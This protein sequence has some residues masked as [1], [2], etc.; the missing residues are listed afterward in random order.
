MAFVEIAK[1]DE[2]R[3]LVYGWANIVKHADGT[4][5]EDSQGDLIDEVELD[6]AAVGFMLNHRTAGEMHIGDPSGTVVEAFVASPSKLTAMGLPDEV[7]KASPTGL[8]VGVKVTPEVF[9]KVKNGTYR[10]FSIHG[11]GTRVEV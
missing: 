8:W 6:K 9:A 2:P 5:V 3:G 7:A 4:V 11:F 10:G 1:T